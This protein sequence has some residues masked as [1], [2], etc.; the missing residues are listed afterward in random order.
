MTEPTGPV[1][2]TGA[3]SGI[4]R[5]IAELLS[6]QGHE[7]IA[8]ARKRPDLEALA[9]LQGVTPLRL[10]VT[11]DEEVEKVAKWVR[12]TGKGLHGLVNN[13]GISGFGALV[14]TPVA[15][16]QRV[17]DVNLYGAHRMTRA[18][19]PFLKASHGRVVNISSVAGVGIAPFFAGYA[20]SKHALEAYSDILRDELAGLGIR[21][22]TIEPGNFRS[23][24]NSNAL[25]LKGPEF[26]AMVRRS[27]FPQQLQGMLD[28]ASGVPPDPHRT[29]FLD[30][31]PVAEAVADALYSATPKARYLVADREGQEQVNWIYEDVL[32]LLSQLNERHPYSLT[33]EELAAR[34]KKIVG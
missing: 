30:P 34:L 15:E 32:T 18:C 28:Y 2:V 19:F 9:R 22:S 5:S 4:G 23:E 24:I 29:R 10:D 8:T 17:L 11:E 31:R 16:L 14:E 20:L 21:V 33:S 1:L 12:D 13:S 25:A 26:K 3:S 7:V 6:S 27:E